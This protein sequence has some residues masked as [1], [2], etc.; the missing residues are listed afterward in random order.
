M[1]NNLLRL[2]V[3]ASALLIATPAQSIAAPG[4]RT[5]TI[6]DS[7]A[8]AT[9]KPRKIRRFG[10]RKRIEKL[11][12]VKST[13]PDV[14]VLTRDRQ[15]RPTHH[16][17]QLAGNRDKIAKRI[18]ASVEDLSGR[19]VFVRD[20]YGRERLVALKQ[21]GNQKRIAKWIAEDAARRSRNRP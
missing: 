8:A 1:L 17:I 5:V 21:A 14:Y 11:A 10:N 12:P 6:E 19:V 2:A 3:I 16:R 18:D 9:K 7:S 4:S 20:V 13:A 15:V